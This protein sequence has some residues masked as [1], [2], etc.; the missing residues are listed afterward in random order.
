MPK[1]GVRLPASFDTAGEFLADVQALEAAGADLLLLGEGPLDPS[2]L[3]AAMASLTSTASLAMPA[4]GAGPELE[5]LRRLSR[6]RRL[7]ELE[8]RLGGVEPRSS[9]AAKW[10]RGRRTAGV[11]AP[12]L[13]R[14]FDEGAILRTHVMRPTWHFVLPEDIRWLLELTSPRLLASLAGRH[15]QLELD[16]PTRARAIDLF[17]GALSGGRSLNRPELGEVLLAAHISPEGQRLPH[18]LL[19]AEALGTI[20]SRPRRGKQFTFA[21]LAEPAPGARRVDREEALAALTTPDFRSHRPPP[22]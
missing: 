1:I 15:R 18:L 17:A 7:Q 2:L 5:T 10:A 9:A 16:E 22:F 13:A 4:A 20:T 19:A 6:G 11:N 21:P 8:G 14:L 3:L 12:D